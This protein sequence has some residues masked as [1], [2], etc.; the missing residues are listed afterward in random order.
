MRP[1]LSLC[2]FHCDLLT[3]LQG[4]EAFHLYRRMVDENILP[5]V[6]FDEAKSLIVIEPLYGSRNSLA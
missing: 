5:A 1:F 6:A 4:F 2:H 3:F